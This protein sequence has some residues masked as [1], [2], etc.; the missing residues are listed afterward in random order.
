MARISGKETKYLTL[1]GG[2]AFAKTPALRRRDC[3]ATKNK[4]E[5]QKEL[6]ITFCF[7]C[8]AEY[9][10]RAWECSELQFPSALLTMEEV[11]RRRNFCSNVMEYTRR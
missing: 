1:Y 3:S 10:M 9:R 6:L 4:V 11:E 2:S 8:P 7:P 5:Q